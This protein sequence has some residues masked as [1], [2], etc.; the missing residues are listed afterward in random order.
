[1]AL[2][3]MFSN[4]ATGTVEVPAARATAP[5][6]RPTLDGAPAARRRGLL[7]S[8][9]R[10]LA[11]RVLS[12]DP[13]SALAAA[14]PLSEL[15]MDSLMAIELR[16]LIGTTLDLERPLSATAA[17]DYPTLGALADHVLERLYPS[18][19]PAHAETAAIAELTDEEAEAALLAELNEA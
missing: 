8:H 13:P 12:L 1:R 16:N 14:Q 4:L 5:A 3:P 19:P 7:L 2:P 11:V 9:L 15:G 17:L 6:F 18:G 10:G